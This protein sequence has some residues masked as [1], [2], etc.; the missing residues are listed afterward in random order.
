MLAALKKS[1]DKS[2]QHIKKQRHPFADRGL[3]RQNYYFSSSQVWMWELNHKESG[4]LKN[5]CFWTMVLEKTLESPL[6]GKEIKLAYP[7]GNQSWIFIG[8]TGAEAPDILATRCKELTYWKRPWCW[9]SWRQEKK[10][11]T[12]WHVCIASLT[13]WTWVWTSSGSR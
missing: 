4:V 10:G 5:W 1:Y 8:R 12:G 9:D 2:R 7:Y 6:D 13:W 11:M 3:S